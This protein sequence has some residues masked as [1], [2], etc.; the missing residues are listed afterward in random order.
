MS[1]H[2][3][4]PRAL[5]AYFILLA[6]L[7]LP[8]F[9]APVSFAEDEPSSAPKG[10]Q[11]AA[12]KPS[13]KPVLKLLGSGAEPRTVLRYTPTPG[14]KLIFKSETTTNVTSPMG[15]MK[16]GP[17]K[18]TTL[19]TFAKGKEKGHV[20]VAAEITEA[21][22]EGAASHPM[23]AT[24]KSAVEGSKGTKLSGTLSDQGTWTSAPGESKPDMAQET[25]QA[26]LLSFFPQ[27]PSEAVGVGAKW[28]LTAR[29]LIRNVPQASVV[30]AEITKIDGARI[31]VKFTE[32]RKAKDVTMQAMGQEIPVESI[33]GSGA[34][35]WVIDLACGALKKGA[36]NMKTTM[37]MNMMGQRMETTSAI[38]NVISSQAPAPV[39]E[40]AK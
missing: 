33:A 37:V 21:V 25:L 19:V 39:T 2:P 17:M 38:S 3:R 40:G 10:K 15:Q 14:T 31:E 12:K 22:L 35:S 11:A 23:A 1:S 9:L 4:S 28:T 6:C 8:A 26:Q 27:L 13:A 29:L 7:A 24:L 20:E 18:A 32:T 16:I 34:G 36:N 30:T 5:P